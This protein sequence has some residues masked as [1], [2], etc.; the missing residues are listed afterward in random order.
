MENLIEGV[1]FIINGLEYHYSKYEKESKKIIHAKNIHLERG[2]LLQ[3]EKVTNSMKHEATAYL[4]RMGQIYYFAKSSKVEKIMP[5]AEIKKI[6]PTIIKFI[7]F[8]MKY[9]AH[10]AV[11]HPRKGEVSE[12]M[13]QVNRLFSTQFIILD[14][15]LIFQIIPNDDPKS[16][17]TFDLIE[18]HHVIK[19]EAFDLLSKLSSSSESPAWDS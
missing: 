12:Y 8:R 2:N 10:R 4:N 18:E 3:N 6:V 17:L 5:P 9:T 16:A 1:R 7:P 14:D 11:D 19:K 15:R 13:Q